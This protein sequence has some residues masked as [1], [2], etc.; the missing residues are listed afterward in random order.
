MFGIDMEKVN[1]RQKLDI[2]LDCLREH[3]EEIKYGGLITLLALSYKLDLRENVS[4]FKRMMKKLEI[5]GYIMVDKVDIYFITLDGYYFKGYIQKHKQDNI[6]YNLS[7]FQS[8]TL[9]I[10]TG[11]AGLYGLFE[12]AKWFYHHNGW[13]LPF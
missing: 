13:H 9:S 12:I 6:K 11:M 10:G 5:D 7:Q 2:I 4:Q 1:Y 8:W 3:N